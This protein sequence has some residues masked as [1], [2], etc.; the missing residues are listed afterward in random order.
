MPPLG[1]QIGNQYRHAV[2][3]FVGEGTVC[4]YLLAVDVDIV[5]MGE[6]IQG[7]Q[8]ELAPVQICGEH[9]QNL[10]DEGCHFPDADTAQGIHNSTHEFPLPVGSAHISVHIQ[11]PDP[12]VGQGLETVQF[13]DAFC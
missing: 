4:R 13:L 11:L 12:G 6:N 7:I 9:G 8:E 10:T 2:D 1:I 3:S 5:Q